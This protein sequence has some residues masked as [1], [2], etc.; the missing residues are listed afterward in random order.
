MPE[1]IQRCLHDK[2]RVAHDASCAKTFT[3]M[4]RPLRD[5]IDKLFL[6]PVKSRQPR[7]AP[8][9]SDST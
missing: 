4:P 8:P 7:L 1:E 2:Y 5:K 3:T 6:D 9:A